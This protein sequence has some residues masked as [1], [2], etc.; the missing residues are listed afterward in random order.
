MLLITNVPLDKD[1]WTKV[2]Q[3]HIGKFKVTGEHI[4]ENSNF[5]ISS[6]NRQRYW[7]EIFRNI[8]RVLQAIYEIYKIWPLIVINPIPQKRESAEI[9]KTIEIPTPKPY[10]FF[11][12]CVTGNICNTLDIAD[13]FGKSLRFPPLNYSTVHEYSAKST[14]PRGPNFRAFAW[15]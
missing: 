13:Y 14:G 4:K 6:Y 1:L 8:Y 7:H 9:L 15:T 5:S 3:G 10:I 2:S 12:P 11:F